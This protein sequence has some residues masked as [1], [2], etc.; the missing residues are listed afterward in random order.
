MQGSRVCM[1][2]KVSADLEN[3]SVRYIFCEKYQ[4]CSRGKW[5]SSRFCPVSYPLSAIFK[6]GFFYVS[7]YETW[8]VVTG[9]GSR[10]LRI[11]PGSDCQIW[12]DQELA[13]FAFLVYTSRTWRFIMTAV[14]YW[15]LVMGPCWKIY[16]YFLMQF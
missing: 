8:V 16:I 1:S 10:T 13:C 4:V 7:V 14:I 2:L 6:K 5:K 15:A 11:A 3:K 9:A 12:P